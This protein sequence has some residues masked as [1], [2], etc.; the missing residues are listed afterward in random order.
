[1][2][3]AFSVDTQILHRSSQKKGFDLRK[4]GDIIVFFLCNFYIGSA[5]IKIFERKIYALE[6]I[7]AL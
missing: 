7:K 5:K 2:L 6:K 1:M 3:T 4:K